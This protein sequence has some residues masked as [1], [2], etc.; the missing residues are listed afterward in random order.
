MTILE[1]PWNDGQVRISVQFYTGLFDQKLAL[2]LGDEICLA[3]LEV[4]HLTHFVDRLNVDDALIVG[5]FKSVTL[6]QI[7][8]QRSGEAVWEIG[9]Q[10]HECRDIQCNRDG[11][12]HQ[13]PPPP[14]G[15]S[16]RL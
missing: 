2:L 8:R 11:Y 15:G 1:P 14:I 13:H 9:S 4:Q 3:Q 16:A 5:L 10:E 6:H 7:V 12:E